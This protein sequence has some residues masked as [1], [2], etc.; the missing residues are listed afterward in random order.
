LARDPRYDILFEPIR[1]GPLV[2]KNRFYQVPH[3][4]GMGYQKPNTAAAMRGMK[5]EGGWAVVSTEECDIHHTSDIS[6]YIEQRL[7]DDS[8]IPQLAKMADAVHEHDSLAA[9]ELSHGGIHAPNHFS[10]TTA[11]APS[12]GPTPGHAP[13][14]AGEMTKRDIREIREVYRKSAL[15]ARTA[16]FD[17]VYVYAAHMLTLPAQFLSRRFNRRT[18]EYG[19]SLENRVR[20]FR[21]LIID[22][23]EAVGDTC[24]I[25]VRFMM[26][27]LLDD[28]GLKSD[29]E[30]IEIV[31]MLG[32]LPDLWDVNVSDWD[33]DSATSRFQPEGFQEPF[34][35]Q[36]KKATTK[37]V[38]GVGRFTSPDTM[39]SQLRRGVLDMIG[40]ARPSIADPFLPK[41]IEQGQVDDI[42]EC[43]GCN[44][45]VS[46]DYTMTPIRCTQNPTMGEEWRRGWHPEIIP[47]AKSNNSILIIG[48]GPSGLECA[49]AL[50]KRGYKVT[51]AESR[52]TFGGRVSSESQLPGLNAWTRV[53][54]YRL[55]QIAKLVNVELFPASSMT[56][57]DVLH[58]GAERVVTATGA[59]WR[60]DGIGRENSKPIRGWDLDTVHTP[61][62]VMAGVEFTGRVVIFDDDHFYIGGLLAE[63]LI[64]SRVD[65]VL[66]TPASVVSYW[67]QYTLEQRFIQ[68]R[69]I[70]I[71]VE[72]AANSNL[73]AIK[74]GEVDYECVY[75]GA[76][77]TVQCDSVILVTSQQQC[78]S[79]YK[80]VLSAWKNQGESGII[81]IDRIGDCKVPGTIAAAVYSGHEYARQVDDGGR[82]EDIPFRM[83]R[84]AVE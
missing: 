3:C 23:K 74:E 72:I 6:P 22:A 71:G 79:L 24:A 29:E 49:H 73:T 45:C 25:A 1:I 18:D 42:R 20:L 38:V 48:G 13:A 17:I 10:R 67:T 70:E 51:V 37:P 53:R 63:K 30:G 78:D 46:G 33:N 26:D 66:V 12:T 50:G 31:A 8:D 56:A 69:L 4:C 43:I 82:V 28:D 34:V 60:K 80:E 61:D 14:Y 55:H 52:E 57:S 39:V 16:G 64:K 36:V 59:T 5:A 27:E 62:D 7:W 68:K 47:S 41:K 83:E 54:D 15:R 40:A 32:E 21:E 35:R 65:V 2:A 77:K 81:S 84:V 11:L 58:F 9:I 44:I 76:K 75:S 19:G